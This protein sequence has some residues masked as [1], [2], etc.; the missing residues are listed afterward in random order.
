MAPRTS[1]EESKQQMASL[2]QQPASSAPRIEVG[3]A[4]SHHVVIVE[5]GFAG[6][7]LAQALGCTPLRVTVT[8]LRN[9]YLFQPLL[10]Q[11]ATAVLSPG[12]IAQPTG[13]PHGPWSGCR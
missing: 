2:D 4:M 8:D 9:Y 5:A 10:Y 13:N 11:V 12:E 3:S 7:S 1:F 6:L